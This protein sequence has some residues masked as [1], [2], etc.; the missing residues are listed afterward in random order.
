MKRGLERKLLITGSVWNLII[1]LLTM[2]SYNSWFN[3]EGAKQ[4]EQVD[5]N[6]ALAG[7]Q[8]LNN[9]SS[10]IFIFG[11]FTL[12]GAIINFL[13]ATK[14]RDNEIQK[15]VMIW[16]GIWAVIQLISMDIVGFLIYM[17]AFIMYT[18]KNKAIKLA[19]PKVNKIVGV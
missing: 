17:F 11:L 15:G 8:M 2:F 12:V 1:A 19:D 3:R 18:A 13:V 16:V 14:L 7:S 5:G 6:V 10:V 4:L 9:I